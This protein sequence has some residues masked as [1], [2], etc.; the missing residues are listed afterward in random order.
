VRLWKRYQQDADAEHEPC[1]VRIPE[2]ADRCDHR[3]LL[4]RGAER[5]QHAD[6]EI[7]AVEDHIEQQRDP[8]DGHEDERQ[9]HF[10][11]HRSRPAADAGMG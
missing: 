9:C 8:H 11:A 7:V 4:G 2:G 1:F 3:I 5:Q 6:A 10:H